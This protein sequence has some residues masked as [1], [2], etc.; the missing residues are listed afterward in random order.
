MEKF[1]TFFERANRNPLRKR[2]LADKGHPNHKDWVDQE[3][4]QLSPDVDN[5]LKKMQDRGVI[6]P[7]EAESM[8]NL[9]QL[10]RKKELEKQYFRTK[11]PK[12]MT[13]FEYKAKGER[14]LFRGINV[15][16][17]D[18]A[19]DYAK[20]NKKVIGDVKNTCKRALMKWLLVYK[21]IL[22]NRK[23]T[24]IISSSL[25]NP[26]FAKMG[27]VGKNNETAAAFYSDRKIY[28]DIDYVSNYKILVHEYAHFLANK[29]PRE[30]EPLIRREYKEMLDSYFIKKEGKP[31]RRKSLEG[32]RNEQLRQQVEKKLKLPSSYAA[33]NFDEWF[34]V[35]MENWKDLPNNKHTYKFKSM[36]KKIL[37]RL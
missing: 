13:R 6:T 23:P 19:L 15:F 28:I 24:M 14:F 12:D 33:T 36:L 34:A 4:Q 21:D 9:K 37:T 26:E 8:R 17:D 27:N 35:L 16:V 22:P 32:A 2:E 10:A 29:A 30:L 5:E 1:T 18:Y 3:S 31:T 20:R 25:L 7:N 11:T